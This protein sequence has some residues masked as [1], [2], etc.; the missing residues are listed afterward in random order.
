MFGNFFNNITAIVPFV[1]AAPFL[2]IALVF[3]YLALRG[4]GQANR[5][6]RNWQGVQGRILASEIERRRSSSGNGGT[7]ISYYP[8]VIYEYEVGGRRYQGRRLSFGTEIGWGGFTN[9]A[10]KKVAQYP[11]GSIVP[12][13]YNPENPN[14]AVL[15]VSAPAGRIYWLL[16]IIMIIA[17]MGTLFFSLMMNG[18][19]S[20]VTQFTSSVAK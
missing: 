7:S 14:D 18:F 8:V 1:V 9:Q 5:A 20:N 3:V 19:V 16:A 12:V 17:V 11:P 10:Q 13:Y 4:R 2:I 6:L 15:E